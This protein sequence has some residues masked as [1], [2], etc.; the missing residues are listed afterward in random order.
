LS[1]TLVCLNGPLAGR[2]FPLEGEALPIGRHHSNRLQLPDLAASRHHCVIE[3]EGAGVFRLRDL[4][5]RRGTFVN[6]VPIQERLLEE[7][8]LVTIGRSL[9]VF[10]VG[11]EIGGRTPPALP[12]DDGTLETTVLLTLEDSLYARSPDV[13]GAKVAA[14]RSGRTARDLQ[15]LLQIS[16]ALQAPVSTEGLARRLLELILAAVPAER[17]TLL[18]SDRGEPEETAAAFAIDRKAGPTEPFRVSRTVVRRALE[19]RAGLLASDVLRPEGL[20]G[21]ESLEAARIRSLLA[22]PLVHLGRPVG[23]LYL[24]TRESRFDEGHLE[25]VTAVA[26]MAAPA[27]AT[28]RRIEWL[29]EENQRLTA[30][31]DADMVGESPRMREVYRLLRRAAATDSTVLLRG[32]SGT[33]KELAARALHKASPRAGRPFVAV[34]CATLSE[35]LLESEL[36]GHERGAFTGA[37]ARKTG[38]VEV[39]DT[40]TLFLDEVGEIPLPLQAKLLRFLQERE[41]ER[42][43][44]TRTIRVDVRV[45][46]ATNRDLEKMIREGTFREDLYYRLNVITL[47]LPPLRER[48]EDVPLLASH[49]AAV[50]SRRLGRAVAGFTPEARACLQRYDWPG[51]VREL[52]N[53]V[54]RAIVLGEGDLIRPEDLPE[55]LLDAGPPPGSAGAR[56]HEVLNETKKRLIQDTLAEARGNVTRAAAVLGLHP[57]YLHRLISS[58]GLRADSKG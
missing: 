7:G 31:L 46:A 57:N 36:F 11:E 17:A 33:G 42:L 45:V 52:A 1:P 13:V 4:A 6:G 12:L 30:S 49:F 20:S 18:L 27:L 19:E 38:R 53:A 58:L 24:D 16:K 47:H 9:F 3:P 51:N 21:A 35:T 50:T 28:A 55:S 15:T 2:T 22:A 40:G 37:V 23:L 56:Y 44:S 25:L 34:N 5:S 54:E 29:E 14:D 10:Q 39:A 26:G 41:F 43:G 8:D 48:R 32:E